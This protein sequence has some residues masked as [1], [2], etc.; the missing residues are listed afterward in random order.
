MFKKCSKYQVFYTI[1]LKQ[2]I[3]FI[4]EDSPLTIE[5]DR[6]AGKKLP[7]FEDALKSA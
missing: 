3:H 4:I 2:S 1:Y 7:I 6:P 5:K